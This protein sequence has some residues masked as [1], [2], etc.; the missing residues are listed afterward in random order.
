MREVGLVSRGRG[1]VG[2]VGGGVFLP[3]GGFCA[4][5]YIVDYDDDDEGG[6]V[7]YKAGGPTPGMTS[8]DH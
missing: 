2:V 4:G 6:D 1:W 3:G 7:G 5:G 8:F